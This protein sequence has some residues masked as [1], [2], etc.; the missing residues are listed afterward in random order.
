M[1]IA[2]AIAALVVPKVGNNA[3]AVTKYSRVT[4][5]GTLDAKH[6]WINRFAPR[7]VRTSPASKAFCPWF[8]TTRQIE[9]ISTQRR[10]FDQSKICW[11][12]HRS[13]K[14]PTKGPTIEYGTNKIAN[15]TAMP[16]ALFCRSGE[17]RTNEVNAV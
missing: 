6:A 16:V 1:P 17:N 9:S 12:D 13:I 4:T 8:K 2:A 7:L 10:T 11:R 5:W 3:F 15:A 14:T